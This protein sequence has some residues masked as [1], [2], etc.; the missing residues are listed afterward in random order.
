MRYCCL[1]AYWALLCISALFHQLHGL[2]H[3]TINKNWSSH[4]EGA[5]LPL[6]GREGKWEVAQSFC[7]QSDIRCPERWPEAVVACSG[8]GSEGV[9]TNRPVRCLGEAKVLG[10]L[11][12]WMWLGEMGHCSANKHSCSWLSALYEVL[13]GAT[14][15]SPAVPKHPEE[16]SLLSRW[17]ESTWVEGCGCGAHCCPQRWSADM[18]GPYTGWMG[19][20]SVSWRWRSAAGCWVFA[21]RCILWSLTFLFYRKLIH[22]SSRREKHEKPNDINFRVVY[23]WK[24]F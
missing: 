14:W 4:G 19:V 15:E 18:A 24:W 2:P 21:L 9:P 8:Q 17:P 6:L 5:V 23:F 10:R 7:S 1:C 11:L 12:A 16:S 20:K 22:R 13:Y 3:I